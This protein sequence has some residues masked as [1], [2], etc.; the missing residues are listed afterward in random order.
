MINSPTVHSFR[1]L[2]VCTVAV[3]A[4]ASLYFLTTSHHFAKWFTSVPGE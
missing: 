4:I 2:F 3:Y 1:K